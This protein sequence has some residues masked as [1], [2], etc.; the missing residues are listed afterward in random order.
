LETV[1]C[2]KAASRESLSFDGNN[3]GIAKRNSPER[4]FCGS[5]AFVQAFPASVWPKPIDL[6]A[7]TLDPGFNP[8]APVLGRM[9]RQQKFTKPAHADQINCD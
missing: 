3:L 2:D 5:S 4:R 8:Q 1:L 9:P 6:A 7:S